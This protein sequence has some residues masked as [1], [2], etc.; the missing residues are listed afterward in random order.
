MLSPLC[1][2]VCV[3]P[4]YFSLHSSPSLVLPPARKRK[5]YYVLHKVKYNENDDFDDGTIQQIYVFYYYINRFILCVC[6]YVLTGE[7]KDDDDDDARKKYIRVRDFS[8]PF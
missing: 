2:C 7:R 8:S 4:F 3:F 1:V 6:V 5:L